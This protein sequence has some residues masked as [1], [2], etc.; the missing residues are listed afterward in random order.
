MAPSESRSPGLL[1]VVEVRV[2]FLLRYSAKLDYLVEFRSKVWKNM[3]AMREST[4]TQ[5][6]MTELNSQVMTGDGKEEIRGHDNGGG[7]PRVKDTGRP[8][9]EVV[10][11]EPGT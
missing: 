5:G 11:L 6:G 1:L 3:Q 4:E 10:Y 9:G 7:V 8:N 2:L